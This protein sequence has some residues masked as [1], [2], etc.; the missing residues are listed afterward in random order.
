MCQKRFCD[1]HRM[2]EDHMCNFN[3]KMRDR[4]NLKKSFNESTHKINTY[5]MTDRG[6]AAY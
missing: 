1:I 4:E 6:N 3:F 5:S 2:P